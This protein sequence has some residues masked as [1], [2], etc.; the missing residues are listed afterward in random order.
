MRKR[1]LAA[2]AI[3]LAVSGIALA[4]V[5]REP[6]KVFTASDV[7]RLE[8]ASNPQISP[9]GKLVAYVRV[10]A[11]IM[12]DR[13][14]RSIWVVDETGASHWPV[15]Q[16]KGNYSSPVWS[17]DGK[18]IAYVAT[19]DGGPEV[20]I[21]DLASRRSASIGRVPTGAQNLPGRRMARCWP[22][23]AS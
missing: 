1:L 8:S 5:P 9:D 13:F 2:A 3:A 17:P 4:Q 16:G 6:V 15:A 10:S 20:R 11:D 23:K 18:S 14:R 21:F 22:S 7:F 19:E 12:T